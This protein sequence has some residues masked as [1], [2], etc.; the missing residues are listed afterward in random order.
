[1]IECINCGKQMTI[2]EVRHDNNY[3]CSRACVAAFEQQK[4]KTL[5]SSG[6]IDAQEMQAIEQSE[7]ALIVNLTHEQLIIRL[8]EYK[9]QYQ[10]L[11]IKE[12]ATH[13]RINKLIALGESEKTERYRKLGVNSDLEAKKKVTS[14]IAKSIV[15]YRKMGMTDEKIRNMMIND[16]EFDAAKVTAA[17][18]EL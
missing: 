8:S 13:T 9:R 4:P 1:M 7:N 15:S 2:P 6:P 11:R 12:R 16:L 17:F 10:E 3:Y 18:S 5:A 14:T